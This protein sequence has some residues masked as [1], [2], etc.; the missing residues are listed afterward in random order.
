MATEM[1]LPYGHVNLRT[2]LPRRRL[3]L[4]LPLVALAV[5]CTDYRWRWDYEQAEREAREQ[6]KYLFIF[7]KWWLSSESN[8][9]HNDILT[10]PE[11]GALF[12]DTINVLLERD[13][14]PEYA[15]YMAQYGVVSPPAFVL[16][17]PDGTMR[18]KTGFVPKERFMEF[19]Q[20]AKS[21]DSSRRRPPRPRARQP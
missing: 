17:A 13:S 21:P 20:R 8:R 15:K 2:S 11:V 16:V 9:M 14:S 12:Q 5:G 3:W 10:E 4:V 1:T 18:K 19:V 7:Y 6:D